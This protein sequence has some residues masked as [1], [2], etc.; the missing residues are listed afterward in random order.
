MYKKII[1]PVL[2]LATLI[3]VTFLFMSNTDKNE[4]AKTENKAVKKELDVAGN[5]EPIVVLELFTS[6]GCSSC[7]TA[8]ALLQKVKNQYPEKLFALSYHVDYWDYIGW[9]DP[10]GSS[11]Y[12]TKQSFYNRKLGYNGNYTPEAIVNGQAHFVGSSPSKLN[13]KIAEYGKINAANKIDLKN[14]KRVDDAISFDFKVEGPLK[15]KLLRAVLVLDERTTSIKRGENANRTLTN[16]NIVVLEKYLEGKGGTG[17]AT[18]EVPN[19]VKANEDLTLMLFVETDDLD[20][21][22]ATKSAI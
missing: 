16:S 21:T 15:D 1:I 10:F 8:D 11:K 18:L 9:R 3:F 22:G 17:T 13:G 4:T 14:A 5:Y 12:T 19:I 20:I 7:P 2:G 6:Q